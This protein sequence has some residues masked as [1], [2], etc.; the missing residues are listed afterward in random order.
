MSQRPSY[1]GLLNAIAV[2]EGEAEE[3]LAC[4]ASVT[5]NDAVRKVISTVALREGEH[6]KA[7]EKRICELGY[8]LRGGERDSDKL[9]IAASTELTDRQKFE[10]LGLGTQSDGPDVFSRMF[11]D[12]TIDIQTGAL[13]GR[14]IAEE[15]D[16]GRML[17]E[18]YDQLCDSDPLD[19]DDA[20]VDDTVLNDVLDRLARI[21]KKIKKLSR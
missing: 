4:W 18:C 21:E 15:R 6:A 2:A 3:Y 5:G 11:D 14:Y 7:F 9:D 19:D 20:A 16:S 10:R 13:L 8:E 1:L 12:K 17:A